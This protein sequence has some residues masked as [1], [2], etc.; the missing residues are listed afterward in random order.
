MLPREMK[1]RPQVL[2][3]RCRFHICLPCAC[4]GVD[5]LLAPALIYTWQIGINYVGSAAPLAG[6]VSDIRGWAEL[7]RSFGCSFNM[8]IVCRSHAQTPFIKLLF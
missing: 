5:V 6:C 3:L 4:I 8:H 1:R 2:T 7:F